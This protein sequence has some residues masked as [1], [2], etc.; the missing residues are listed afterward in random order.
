M[1][2]Y[3]ELTAGE[4]MELTTEQIQVYSLE[5]GEE[6]LSNIAVRATISRMIGENKIREQVKAIRKIEKDLNGE[7]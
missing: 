2:P 6:M 3:N 1:K 4:I 5:V 7:D